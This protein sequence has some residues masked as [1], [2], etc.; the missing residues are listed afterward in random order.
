MISSAPGSSGMTLDDFMT[1]LIAGLAKRGIRVVSIRGNH[2]DAAVEN[3]FLCLNT[4]FARDYNIP[5]RFW[6]ARNRIYGDSPDIR[7]GIAKAV[8]RD[9]VSLDNPEY[10]DMRLKIGADDADLYLET[11]PG[12]SSLYE[13]LAEVFLEFYP[14]ILSDTD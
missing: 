5:L 11:L 9:L 8:Q 10:Q 4:Q 6:I 1:G 3:V 2:F 12:D 13:K 14:A 7:E